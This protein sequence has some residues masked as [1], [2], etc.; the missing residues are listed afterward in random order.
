MASTF[1]QELQKYQGKNVTVRLPI[2]DGA[3]QIGLSGQL[4]TVGTDHVVVA[5]TDRTVVVPF[6]GISFVQ[7]PVTPT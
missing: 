3:R 2:F 4:N 7:V 5:T 6:S 1:T